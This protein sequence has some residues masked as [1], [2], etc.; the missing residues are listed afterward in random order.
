MKNQETNVISE[1]EL[2]K[3]N[4]R[5]RLIPAIVASVFA[6][7]GT[8]FPLFFVAE[9]G[10]LQFT[11]PR[12]SK[13]EEDFKI[14]KAEIDERFLKIEKRL[15]EI[16]ER[17]VDVKVLP[18]LQT[19][20]SGLSALSEDFKDLSEDFKK[21]QRIIQPNPAEALTVTLLEKEQERLKGD[22]R[23]MQESMRENRNTFWIVFGIAVPM[24]ISIVVSIWVLVL[25]R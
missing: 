16:Y 9:R 10:L 14:L 20:H 11:V 18:E 6:L 21:I 7:I 1:K 23:T 19:L 2:K 15:R 3:R 12:V 24:F 4:L 25:R 22:L 8:A 13:V 5:I 17:P